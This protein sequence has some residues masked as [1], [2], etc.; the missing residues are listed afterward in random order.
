MFLLK[1]FKFKKSINKIDEFIVDEDQLKLFCELASS[2]KSIGLD[3]EGNGFYRYPERVCLIQVSINDRPFIIDPLQ[4]DDLT[5]LGEI[6]NNSKITKIVH[7]GDYDIRSLSRDYSF[8]F[9]NVFDTSI[10][11]AFLGSGRL[12]LDAVLKEHLNVEVSKDKRLQRSDWTIRPLSAEAIT[13]AANDVRYLVNAM[14][15]MSDKLN[16]LGRFQ[17]VQE[18]FKRLSAVKYEAKDEEVAFLNVKGSRDIEGQNLAVLRKLYQFREDEAISKDRPPFKVI[19]DSILVAI[20]RNPQGNFDD[21]KGIGWW[22]RPEPSSRLKKVI[23]QGLEAP[24]VT[25]PKKKDN[26]RQRLSNKQRERANV[27]LRSLKVWRKGIGD[28]LKLDP[29]ILW[30]TSS[31]NRL[32]RF[33]NDFEMEME[34]PEVRLWQQKE[35]GES[36]KIM[37]D[38]DSG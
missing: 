3:I 21:I 29:S 36:L 11:A 34:N 8:T 38:K 4:F 28:E 35:F 25:R 5:S 32:S 24:P 9:N 33:P 27:R 16:S 30:P 18:E 23:K 14:E 22:G 31:L 26:E 37:I 12:G 17:W 13:Y 1:R 20:A 19:S 6:F 15:T 10:A 7:A 2:Q